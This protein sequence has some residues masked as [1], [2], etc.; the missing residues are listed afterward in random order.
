[1]SEVE[2]HHEHVARMIPRRG[3]EANQFYVDAEL[4]IL[5]IDLDGVGEVWEI[6]R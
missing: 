1:M 6:E 5:R 4:A 2:M 3:A